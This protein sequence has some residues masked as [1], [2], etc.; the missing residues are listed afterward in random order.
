MNSLL[1]VITPCCIKTKFVQTLKHTSEIHKDTMN[2]DTIQMTFASDFCMSYQADLIRHL[3]RDGQISLKQTLPGLGRSFLQ[4]W[5]QWFIIVS[6]K[7]SLLRMCWPKAV[8]TVGVKLTPTL[9]INHR[10]G[11]WKTL[12]VKRL[13][14]FLLT[15]TTLLP[16]LRDCSFFI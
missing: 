2:S 16:N 1:G 13:L 10:L 9:L 8:P 14:T 5:G 15:Q 11:P 7:R 6:E 12:R 4:L 3:L